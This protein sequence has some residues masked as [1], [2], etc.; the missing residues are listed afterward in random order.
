LPRPITIIPENAPELAELARRFTLFAEVDCRDYSPLYERLS[1]EIAADDELLGLLARA[2]P[3]Q[4]RPVLFLAAA[5]Y[6]GGMRDPS[7]F[8]EFCLDHRDALVEIIET[9]ATQTNEVRRCAVLLPVF[10]RAPAPLALVEVGTSAGLNLLF[11]RYGYD[12]GD[13]RRFGAGPP[14]LECS[15][16]GVDVDGFPEVAWRVGIDREPVDVTDDDAVAWLRACVFADQADR[17]QRL[18]DAVAVAR[19]DP[20]RIV[21]GDAREV[22]SDVVLS[23]PADAHVVVFHTWVV[24]YFLRDQRADFFALFDELGR[25]RDLTWLSGESPGTIPDLGLERAT[26][27]TLG[28]IRYEGG[29][30]SVNV[31]GRA[32]PHGN[33]LELAD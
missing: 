32:H 9:R 25:Q 15:A 14:V 22:L 21:A 7:T 20:P 24:T 3:G 13:G 26:Q 19:R 5:N 33:W 27:M 29:M 16:P 4:R 18:N 10:W 23:A 6:L 17:V 30:K 28:E 31:I 12:Y 1:L 2:R 8:R 11:D